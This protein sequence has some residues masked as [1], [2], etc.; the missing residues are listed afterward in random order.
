MKSNG[1]RKSA[2]RF[3]FYCLFLAVFPVLNYLAV[4]VSQVPLASTTR[5]A[6]ASLIFGLLLFGT[7]ILILRDRQKAGL[8]TSLTLILFYSYG[9][10]YT[11]LA[12]QS[13]PLAHHRYLL[14]GFALVGALF[15]LLILRIKRIPAIVPVPLNLVTG[16]LVLLQF[17]PITAYQV[18]QARVIS[19]Q[20]S[21][22]INQTSKN[23][24]DVYYIIV[25]MYARDDLL[26]EE[27][28]YDNSGFLAQ[29]EQRGFYVASCALSN[30]TQTEL[31]LASSL[32]MDYLDALGDFQPG[33]VD[34][35]LAD[36][37]IQHSRVRA[38]FEDL[39][40]GIISLSAY[41]PLKMIDAD[42]YFDTSL[43]PAPTI[44]KPQLFSAF[45]ALFIKTTL[46]RAYLDSPWAKSQ[47]MAID[48]NYP[49]GDHVRQ[50][51]YILD[52]LPI[53]PSDPRPKF[54]FVHIQLPH[55]PFVFTAEGNIVPDPLPFPSA[56][57]NIP[58]EDTIRNYLA[59][60]SYLNTRLIPILDAI[61]LNS[62]PA[63][64]I[65]LQA[66]HGPYSLKKPVANYPAIL[67]AILL[68]EA[69]RDA[70]YAELSPVNTFRYLFKYVLGQD[71]E[72]LPDRSYMSTYADPYSY[73]EIFNDQPGCQ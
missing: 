40:Y 20:P 29:L 44:L 25:D 26:L 33:S 19:E 6:A 5:L 30:Y 24:P 16:L 17:I 8:V 42:I 49:Y 11:W 57:K 4:N 66:D 27:M 32:N 55:P 21:Q 47:P 48:I 50:Q 63:P 7:S 45:E 35:T 59:Q 71:F 68:P 62:D 67:N 2:S 3:P 14:P 39:G 52:T 23:R 73:M 58:R 43:A 69:N 34:R 65:I 53:I 31:S 36:A 9:H 51:L 61:V 54:V 10:L 41:D 64:V 70:L 60:T 12:E 22:N 56:G 37:L 18:R 46:L 72:L 1:S 13:N 15:L 28:A 38:I